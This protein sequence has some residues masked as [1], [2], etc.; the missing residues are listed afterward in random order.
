MPKQNSNM[1]ALRF[2]QQK[3]VYTVFYIWVKNWSLRFHA[4]VSLKQAVC[5]LCFD[6]NYSFGIQEVNTEHLP[7]Y[8]YIV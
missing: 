8:T 1:L 6:Y 2:L 7:L 5:K 4:S 3:H